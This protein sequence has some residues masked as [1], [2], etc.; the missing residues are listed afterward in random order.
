MAKISRRVSYKEF[1]KDKFEEVVIKVNRCATVVKGGRR[2]SFSAIVVIGNKN[3]VAGIGFGKANEVPPAVEKAVKNAQKN[4]YQFP[5]QG[6]TIPHE[7]I[8]HFGAS[9]VK[10]IPAFSGTGVIAGGTV[11]ALMEMAGYKDILTKAY[12]SSNPS[13]L[14]KATLDGLMQ[15]RTKEEVA[16][17]RG[18][19]V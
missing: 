15:L 13:N 6:D 10:L 17:L 2:F 4:L 14:I 16:Q 7:V 9:K 18:V 12:G 19:P 11:R 5:L 3:G 8:G 1:A